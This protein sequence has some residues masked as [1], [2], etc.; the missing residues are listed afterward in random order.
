MAIDRELSN[1]FT[2]SCLAA[3]GYD[4]T[5]SWL[6]GLAGI[7]LTDLAHN[8]KQSKRQAIAKS[9]KRHT[10]AD[11]DLHA[12]LICTVPI[13]ELRDASS[14]WHVLSIACKVKIWKNDRV[15]S[16]MHP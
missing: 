11:C 3:L 5:S 8:Y 13:A 14:R 6:T 10:F 16:M 9:E 2:K 15:D 4:Q 1:Q 12:K 7:S